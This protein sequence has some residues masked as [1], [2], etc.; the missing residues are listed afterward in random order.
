MKSGN[1][2]IS[3]IKVQNFKNV[4]YG[5]LSLENTRKPYK[6]SVL[7]LYGQNGSG[8]TALVDS[9]ELLKN[10]MSGRKIPEKFADYINVSAGFATLT[11][12]FLIEYPNDSINVSYQF[13]IK[14][15]NVT[16]EQNSDDVKS[17]ERK[18]VIFNE[19]LKCPILSE[20]QVKTGRL[21]DTSGSEIF[22]PISKKE[23]LV[24]SAKD[25]NNDL[26]VAKKFTSVTSR[27]F[28]FSRE[29][30]NLIRIRSG[31]LNSDEFDYYHSILENLNVY[32]NIGLF[33]VNTTTS[34]LVSQNAQPIVFKYREANK[35]A[36]GKLALFLDEPNE[37]S[38]NSKILVEK[39]IDN[40]NIALQQIIPGLTVGIKNLG[41]QVMDNGEVGCRIQLMSLKNNKEIALKYE[42]E[43]IKKIISVLQL[44]IVVYNDPSTTV[45][46]DELDS[47]VFEYLLGELLRIIS[48]KGRGQLIFTSHNLRPLETLD[49]GFVAFTTTDPEQRYI[50]LPNVKETNN[51]RDIYYRDIILDEHGKNL[52]EKT[53]NAEI[54]FAFREAGKYSGA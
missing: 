15:D 6:A 24:G 50:R 11:F 31:I 46:V 48:E 34:G 14:S 4:I 52:Y 7:G 43:G 49:R 26:L 45:V 47:G 41:T 32:G 20:K 44:L 18:V 10:A 51:L 38:Q 19:L 25:V 37:I 16:I 42:S 40:M 30:I 35:G 17:S 13:S 36:F 22:T 21:I 3:H 8:K 23:L 5:E 33:V 1:V 12:D 27:S 29:L 2:R 9:L 28:I 53:N 39:I 54:A